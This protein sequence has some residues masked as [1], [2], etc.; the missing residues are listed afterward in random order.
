M[1]R[2]SAYVPDTGGV[3]KQYEDFRKNRDTGKRCYKRKGLP[4]H[5]V[6]RSNARY[7]NQ[8]TGKSQ[9]LLPLP[10]GFKVCDTVYSL[11]G[12][13]VG[14]G[15]QGT[16]IGKGEDPGRSLCVLF[17][18]VEGDRDVTDVYPTTISY[19]KPDDS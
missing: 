8:D 16:I 3:P 9:L 17:T 4:D 14:R 11:F 13:E 5:W 1:G 2:S 19:T 18:G 15:T 12:N 6:L 10:G 7:H